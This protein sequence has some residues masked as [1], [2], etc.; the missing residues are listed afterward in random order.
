MMLINNYDLFIFDLDDTIVYTEHYHY[1][2]WLYI[3]K[4]EINQDFFITYTVFCSKFHSNIPSSI[5]DYLVNELNLIDYENI[6]L[7][8]NKYYLNLIHTEAHNI[9]L[10]PGFDNFITKILQNNKQFVIVSNSLK[11]N[12]DFF[13]NLFPVLQNSSKNYYREMF[14]NKK[15]NS[16]CY[17][18]V[19]ADFPNKQLIGF[20][21]SITGIH[22]IN[23]VSKIDTVFIN[24]DK[25]YYYKYIISNYNIKYVLINYN[26]ILDHTI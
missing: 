10:I 5:K 25:Y 23:Q 19:L 21:D 6:I 16:E 22:A 7:K 18:Q 14:I 9:C 24:N 3:L 20:E 12:I 26:T 4:N 13:V 8:K 1:N 15:P 11:S 17:L 2:S